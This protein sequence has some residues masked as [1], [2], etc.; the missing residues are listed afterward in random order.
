VIAGVLARTGDLSIVFAVS[1]A[2]TGLAS[3]ILWRSVA[4]PM[5]DPSPAG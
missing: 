3:A 1:A 2:G 4:A 5:R